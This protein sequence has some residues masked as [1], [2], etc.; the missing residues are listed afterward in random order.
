MGIKKGNW[1][2]LAETTYESFDIF[3]LKKSTRVNPRTKKRFDFVRIDGLD[4]ANVIPIT[5]DN[6]V[7]LIKQY[8]HGIDDYTFEIPGGCVELGEDP[9]LS[10]ARELEEETGY[11][12]PALD[13]LGCI[14]PN[15]ALLSNRCYLY[16]ARNVTLK[17]RQQLDPGEDIEVLL[18]PFDEVVTMVKKGDISHALVVA[19]F[20]LL[21]LGQR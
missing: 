19:A 10:A 21:L 2:V 9:S 15:P 5:P 20:G 8:R 14:R 1:E 18:K 12:A 3:S 17:G 7:V 11:H 16:V 6:N 13:Y 4:W